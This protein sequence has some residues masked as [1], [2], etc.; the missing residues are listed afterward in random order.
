[1]IKRITWFVSGAAAGIAG[2]GYT[3]RKVK[4]TAAQLAPVHVAKKVIAG[5]K[6]R[7]SNVTDA[8]REG[9]SAMK[10]KES[11]LRARRDGRITSLADQLQPNDEVLVEGRPVSAG[12][13]IVLHQ[14]KASRRNRRG[15]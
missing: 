8:V 13:V 9:R 1:M 14:D 12:Q 2:A 5:A 7:V 4:A 10:V 15:A 11:E 6:A 3:K